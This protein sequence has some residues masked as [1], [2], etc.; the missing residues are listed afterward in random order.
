MIHTPVNVVRKRSITVQLAP[1][2][3][4]FLKEIATAL[5]IRMTD[6]IRGAAFMMLMT[7]D[8]PYWTAREN[9]VKHAA[10]VERWR[11]HNAEKGIDHVDLAIDDKFYEETGIPRP[12]GGDDA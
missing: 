9:H 12:D 6:V 3:H 1:D 8:D 4:G 7:D 10:L 11:R 5:N 2:E